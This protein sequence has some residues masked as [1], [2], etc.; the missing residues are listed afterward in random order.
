MNRVSANPQWFSGPSAHLLMRLLARRLRNQKLDSESPGASIRIRH[1]QRICSLTLLRHD[2]RIQN[3]KR[4]QTQ[5]RSRVR[6]DQS[7]QNQTIGGP[8]S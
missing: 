8:R 2:Q 3:I 6:L 1:E 4:A 5:I 7:D